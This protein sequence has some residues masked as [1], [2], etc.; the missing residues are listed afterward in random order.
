MLK[1]EPRQSK[2]PPL[3]SMEVK[4]VVDVV[5]IVLIQ[6]LEVLGVVQDGQGQSTTDVRR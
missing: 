2:S 5:I 4:L 3:V 1:S 6:T